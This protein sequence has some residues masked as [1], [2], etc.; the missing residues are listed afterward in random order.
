MSNFLFP[1]KIL[2][3]I[4]PPDIVAPH[5]ILKGFVSFLLAIEFEFVLEFKLFITDWEFVGFWMSTATFSMAG[6]LFLCSVWSL[7]TS[8]MFD[9]SG[10]IISDNIVDAL[11]CCFSDGTL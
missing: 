4:T 9:V 1:E 8:S 3:L 11:F 5:R 7:T 10:R 6:V 2:R